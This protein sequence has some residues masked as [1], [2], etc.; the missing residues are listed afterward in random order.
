MTNKEKKAN[1]VNSTTKQRKKTE[2]TKCVRCSKPFSYDPVEAAETPRLCKEC[3]N[4]QNDVVF[5]GTCKE[6]GGV[7]YIKRCDAEFFKSKG[8]EM[9]K[10]CYE[11]RKHRKFKSEKAESVEADA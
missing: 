5:Q 6:W 3:S 9:P 2:R 10:R 11:C 4:H 7:F 8:L 1:K